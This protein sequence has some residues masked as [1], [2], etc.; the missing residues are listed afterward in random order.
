M[1]SNYATIKAFDNVLAIKLASKVF[2]VGS[3]V[4]SK[5]AHNVLQKRNSANILPE[6]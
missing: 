3:T 1:F 4:S 2:S 5:S 6:Q